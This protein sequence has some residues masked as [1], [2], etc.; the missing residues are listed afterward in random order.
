MFICEMEYEVTRLT[1]K[2]L[3]HFD[4]D[5][6]SCYDR[7]NVC[8][9]NVVSRKFGQSR[10]V[11]IVEGRT[12]AEARYHL[13]TK[14]GI[15]DEFVQHCQFHPWFGNGQGAGDS[16]TKWLVMSSTLFDEYET[17]ATGALYE[18]PDGSW[19]LQLYLVG[20]VDDMRNSINGFAN[21]ETTMEELCLNAQQDCQLWHDLLGVVNQQLELPKCGYHAFQFEFL[22]TG[23]PKLINHPTTELTIIDLNG[24]PLQITQWPNDKAAKY[25][26][27]QE[28]LSNKKS[29]LEA[30]TM[31]C[32]GHARI[33][34][35][36]HLNRMETTTFYQSI[37][38]PSIGFCLPCSHFTEQELHKAQTRAHRAFIAK[39]GY[40]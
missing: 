38:R 18:S 22:P 36:C 24:H 33:I 37:Y 6:T 15:S 20:F 10:K 21:P 28:S 31:K 29:Q 12:L 13:K 40:N 9:A 14:L 27:H 3:I 5:A 4:N 2:P 34:H 32:D 30:I 17:R 23:E 1:R 19:S 39:M 25:L 16:P 35:C 26:G 7:I 11:C 8:I